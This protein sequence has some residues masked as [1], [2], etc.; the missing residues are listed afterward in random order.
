VVV[1]DAAHQADPL[2]AGGINLGMF[3]ADMA[4]QVAVPAVLDGD[5]RR[6]RLQAYEKL[7][8]QRFGKEH[9]ALYKIRKIIAGMDQERLDE[10]IRQAAS[11]PLHEMSLSQILMALL[12]N[13]PM[14]L[15]EARKLISTGLLIK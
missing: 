11:L 15:L 3:G 2:T 13:D 6:E 4:M 7:W 10:L 5:T 1:G 9:A 14:L 12:K 8:Q